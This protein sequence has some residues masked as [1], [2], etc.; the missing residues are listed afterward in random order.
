[1]AILDDVR[2]AAQKRLLF[3]PHAIRQMSRPQRMI[4]TDEVEIV[5]TQGELIEDYPSD[6]RGHSCLMLGLGEAN[7]AVHVVCSPKDEYLAIITAYLP[8]PTQW[9]EDFRRRR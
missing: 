7:R 5:V 8:D 3:L 2:Y 1:M 9:S 4:S 6:P